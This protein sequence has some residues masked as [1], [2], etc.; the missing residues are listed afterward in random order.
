MK[1]TEAL[2]EQLRQQAKEHRQEAR[3]LVQ[4]AEILEAPKKSQGRPVN[5]N[6]DLQEAF[7]QSGLTYKELAA[8]VG[9]GYRYVS[10]TIRGMLDRPILTQRIRVAL[11]PS[12]GA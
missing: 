9:I 5:P 1:D 10:W 7:Q 6:R 2:A 3:R 8:K 12:A 4:A 11:L